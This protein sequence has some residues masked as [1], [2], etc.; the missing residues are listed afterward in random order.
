[1][2]CAQVFLIVSHFRVAHVR[3]DREMNL[4][5]VRYIKAR[6]RYMYSRHLFQSLNVERERNIEFGQTA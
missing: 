2:E 5:S 1:M 4:C 3:Y 6:I